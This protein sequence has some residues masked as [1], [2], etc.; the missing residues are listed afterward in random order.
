M[1]FNFF[2]KISGG[3]HQL[4]I[5]ILQNKWYIEYYFSVVYNQGVICMVYH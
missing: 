3:F 4:C 5:A 2:K 1:V